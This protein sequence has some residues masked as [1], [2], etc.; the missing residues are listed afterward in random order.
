M[1][2]RVAIIGYGSV[3]KAHIEALNALE[4][5]EVTNLV[6]GSGG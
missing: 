5:A 3:S 6:K 1:T 2:A 4:D